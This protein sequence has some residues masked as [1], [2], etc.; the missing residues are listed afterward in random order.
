MKYR[1][2]AVIISSI[3]ATRLLGF[4][5]FSFVIPLLAFLG[6]YFK[7]E[8]KSVLLALGL[9]E[10]MLGISII[11]VITLP[12]LYLIYRLSYL[13]QKTTLYTLGSIL[14]YHLLTN[15]AY[16][17]LFMNG[18]VT[19]ALLLAT[20]FLI[21]QVVSGMLFYGACLLLN[22]KYLHLTPARSRV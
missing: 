21:K 7:K 10:V 5:S 13:T 16:A 9:S 6:V 11:S 18:K 4:Q 12:L 8:D 22:K 19:E 15:M 3:I 1:S 17:F 14:M 2:Q 20:P